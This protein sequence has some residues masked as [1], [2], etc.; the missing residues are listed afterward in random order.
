M[1]LLHETRDDSCRTSRINSSMTIFSYNW[2]DHGNIEISFKFIATSVRLLPQP[3]LPQI[4]EF[5]S[6]HREC[7]FFYNPFRKT[8]EYLLETRSNS[9]VECFTRSMFVRHTF[10]LNTNTVL[11]AR[12]IRASPR[13][14]HTAMFSIGKDDNGQEND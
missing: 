7:C 1:N 5:S 4:I 8:N 10:N 11:C 14:S 2:I 13:M 9:R 3:T 6:V 12:L